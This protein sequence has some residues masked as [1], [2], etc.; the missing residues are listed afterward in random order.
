MHWLL[1]T[2]KMIPFNFRAI[3]TSIHF[4]GFKK[5]EISRLK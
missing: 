5:Y 2:L 1:T 4:S 3:A